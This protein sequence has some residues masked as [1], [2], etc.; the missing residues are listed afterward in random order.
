MAKGTKQI[1]MGRVNGYLD[2]VK[3]VIGIV[4][5][6]GGIE[7]EDF[8][9][10]RIDGLNQAIEILM[11]HFPEFADQPDFNPITF[12]GEAKDGRT[13]APRKPSGKA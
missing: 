9:R 3:M 4:E 8:A 13:V 2:A 6:Y 7:G 10:G 11:D 5:R 1:R 12:I